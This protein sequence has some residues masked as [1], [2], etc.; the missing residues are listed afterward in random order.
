MSCSSPRKE[1]SLLVDIPV[2]DDKI[3]SIFNLSNGTPIYEDTL[4]GK[5]VLDSLTY[6][7]HLFTVMWDRD[8]IS[9]DEFKSLRPHTLNNPAYYSLQKRIFIDP[10]RGGVIRLYTPGGMTK[11]E[12]EEQLISPRHTFTPSIEVE[13]TQT[14]LYDVYESILQR[15]RQQFQHQRDSLQN[16]L[17]RYNDQGDL[18]QAAAINQ[19]LKTLWTNKILP[20]YDVEEKQFLIEHAH[21]IIVPFILHN[22]ITSQEIYQSFKPVIDA[23]PKTYQELSFIQSLAKLRSGRNTP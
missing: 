19:Q 18:R 2:E 12:I 14:K 17:Y 23:M 6:G 3:V 8:V 20:L 9:P 22:R 16:L 5:L 13:G 21:D 7:I 4:R 11:E 15:H 1:I 10:K